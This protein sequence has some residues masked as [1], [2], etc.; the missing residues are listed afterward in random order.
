ML[1]GIIQA[2][3][4]TRRYRCWQNDRTERITIVHIIRLTQCTTVTVANNSD[5]MG[6]I[7]TTT[8]Y[9]M[10]GMATAIAT[11]TN[12]ML[13]SSNSRINIIT[14]ITRRTIK[15]FMRWT[16][17]NLCAPMIQML[18]TIAMMAAAKMSYSAAKM[19]LH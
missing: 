1:T 3:M 13:I 4:I 17:I 5:W 16:M 14:T 9:T 10:M 18:N 6:A 15:V 12:T 11:T 7:N 8:T 2:A 19:I